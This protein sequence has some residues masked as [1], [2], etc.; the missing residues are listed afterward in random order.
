MFTELGS[1][2]CLI[3][4]HPLAP[5]KPPHTSTDSPAPC[6]PRQL[7]TCLLPLWFCLF[8]MSQYAAFRVW[9]LSLSMFSGVIRVVACQRFLPF[10]GWIVP[11]PA[12]MDLT[13]CPSVGGLWGSF[14]VLAAV[15]TDAL[16]SVWPGFP[17]SWA[18]PGRELL[19]TSPSAAVPPPSPP[20]VSLCIGSPSA[21]RWEGGGASWDLMRFSLIT[22]DG[23]HLSMSLKAVFYLLQ[24]T[25]NAGHCH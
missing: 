6:S 11:R 15:S 21:A 7:L 9:L 1:H 12:W 22:D 3:L 18:G 24:R 16:A 17:F 2:Q 23:K 5:K 19:L 25:V 8:G 4:D 13:S 14:H 10:R 20:A